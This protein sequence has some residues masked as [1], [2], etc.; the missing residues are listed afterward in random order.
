MELGD[1][2]RQNTPEDFGST[3]RIPVGVLRGHSTVEFSG[4]ARG[5]EV[6]PGVRRW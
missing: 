1:K 4:V 6:S 2:N 3:G 5:V